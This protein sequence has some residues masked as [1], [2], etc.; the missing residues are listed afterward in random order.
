[1]LENDQV[2]LMN[3]SAQLL[4]N[5]RE[6]QSSKQAHLGLTVIGEVGAVRYVGVDLLVFSFLCHSM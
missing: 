3:T 1:M 4:C 5:W 2:L 6:Q